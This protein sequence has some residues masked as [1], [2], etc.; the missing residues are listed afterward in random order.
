MSRRDR[1]VR[2]SR[3]ATA[4]LFL[5]LLPVVVNPAV[6]SADL[7]GFMGWVLA[8]AGFMTSGVWAVLGRQIIRSHE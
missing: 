5:C 4:A 6:F 7:L 3:V 8:W 2:T 1:L